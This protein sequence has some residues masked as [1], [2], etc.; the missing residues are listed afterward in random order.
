M[1]PAATRGPVFFEHLQGH[2]R[3]EGRRIMFC[4]G[5]TGPVQRLRDP[6]RVVGKT[7]VEI[8][9]FYHASQHI[10]AVA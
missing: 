6:L 1:G 9:D 2:L 3:P 4:F 8:L 7:W 10:W 5:M